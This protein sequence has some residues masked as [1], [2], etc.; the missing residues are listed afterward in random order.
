[1]PEKGYVEEVFRRISPAGT[2]WASD[3]KWLQ[4]QTIRFPFYLED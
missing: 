2:F 4:A 3:G 1:L